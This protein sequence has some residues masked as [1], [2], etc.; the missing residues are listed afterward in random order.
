MYELVLVLEFSSVDVFVVDRLERD[1]DKLRQDIVAAEAAVESAAEQIASDLAK[2]KRLRRQLAL[3]ED[4]R[5]K[6]MSRESSSLDELERME[7][8]QHSPVPTPQRNASSSVVDPFDLIDW[9]QVGSVDGTAAA[10]AGS[11]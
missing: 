5:K 9:N 1:S 6:M 3:L 11:S 7:G 10:S 4:R 8:V 2:A